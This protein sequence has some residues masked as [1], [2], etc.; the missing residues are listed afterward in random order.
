MNNPAIQQTLLELEESLS[1]IESARTQVNNVTEKSEEII[2]SFNNILKSIESISDGVGIDKDAIKE[3][4]DKSFT[5]FENELKGIANKAE[6]SVKEV[7]EDFIS[8]K[9]KF[10]ENIESGTKSIEEDFKKITSNIENKTEEVNNELSRMSSEFNK[11]LSKLNSSLE[12][13]EINLNEAEKRIQE[14]NFNEEF[15]LL[16][17]QIDSK[18]RQNL[19]LIGVCTSI[20]IAL[21]LIFR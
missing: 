8:Q 16:S 19:I 10:K 3:N 6:L 14:L 2:R 5:R 12:S 18:H 17:K 7:N 21:I 20:L 9:I 11:G 15:K 13:F 1:K 4:L